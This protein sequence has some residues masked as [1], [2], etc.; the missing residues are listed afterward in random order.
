MIA[1][2]HSLPHWSS[3]CFH[4]DTFPLSINFLFCVDYR[5]LAI[6]FRVT[7]NNLKLLIDP[8]EIPLSLVFLLT[9]TPFTP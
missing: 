7:H 2:L 5:L 6:S 4:P 9:T 3:F 8:N 1:W